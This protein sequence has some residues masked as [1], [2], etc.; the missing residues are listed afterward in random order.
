MLISVTRVRLKGMWALPFFMYHIVRSTKQLNSTAGLLHSDLTRDGW[1]IGWTISVWENKDRMLEYRN[2]GNHAKAMRIARRIG[3]EFEAVHWEADTI[4]SW[5]EAKIR[6][7]Q[8]YG[9]R[10]DPHKQ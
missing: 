1:I 2:H 3:D 4:P 7:H 6:L 9:R 10:P 8:K 5:K